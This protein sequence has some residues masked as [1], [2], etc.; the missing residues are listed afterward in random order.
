MDLLFVWYA[1][2]LLGT[3]E[4]WAFLAAG[5]TAAYFILGFAIPES[6]TWKKHRP[7]F[8]KFLLILVPSLL[9]FLGAAFAIKTFAPIPRPCTPCTSSLTDCLS[10]DC[11]SQYCNPYCPE[12]SSFPSGHA[13]TMFT[14]F[15]SLYLTGRKKLILPLFIIPVLV[16]YS[17]VALGVHTWIDVLAGAILGLVIPILASVM[18]QKRHKPQ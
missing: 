15:T 1:I 9:I 5:L 18:L 10:Q 12:D 3:P 4:Y 8:R 13:G 17:R 7:F 11:I 16:S 6:Q 14:V 2:T